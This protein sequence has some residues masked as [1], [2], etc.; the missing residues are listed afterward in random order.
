[1]N[2]SGNT[3]LITGGASGIGFAFA[4][5]LFKGGNTI[6]VCG[7]REERLREVQKQYPDIHTKVVD[8]AD[9]QDRIRLVEE[10]KKDF[11]QLNVL[12]NN[13][14][15]QRNYRITDGV[16]S[17]ADQRGELATNL[18]API[19]LTTLLLPHLQ[20]QE[21]AAIVNVTSGLAFSP[22]ASAPVYCATK[23]ALHSFTLS[24]RHQLKNSKIEVVEIVPPGVNTDL[25]GAGLH[26]WGVP[27]DE[28]ADGILERLKKGEQEI[29]YGSSERNRTASRE[30]LDS[31]FEQMNNR[32]L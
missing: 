12:F 31:V 4:E 10:V 32:G 16:E 15:V 1:M 22:K 27:V 19:H 11:P 17:W 18:D 29:G 7:R 23:A 5:R 8:I 25:G 3:I 24:L 20:Q 28:F 13:A 14:G 21:N 30:E 26:T 9:E 6:I 2:L